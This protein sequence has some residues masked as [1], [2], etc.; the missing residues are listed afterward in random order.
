MVGWGTK[1]VL[2][3]LCGVQLRIWWFLCITNNNSMHVSL[4]VY[5]WL[6]LCVSKCIWPFLCTS[7]FH[8]RPLYLYQFTTR[9]CSSIAIWVVHHKNALLCIHNSSLKRAL[10]R[11]SG[12]ISWVSRTRGLILSSGQWVVSTILPNCYTRVGLH[13]L[14]MRGNRQVHGRGGIKPRWVWI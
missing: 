7:P 13:Y 3:T 12:V 8:C 6:W 1:R 9:V 2:S 14:G 5:L 4:S 10:Y 11:L